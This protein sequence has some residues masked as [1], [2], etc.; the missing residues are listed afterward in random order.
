M[1]NIAFPEFVVIVV[2]ALIVIGPDKLPKVAQTLGVMVGRMQR[3]M[4][5]I[6]SD[7]DQELRNTDLHR[8]QDELKLQ[9]EGLNEELRKGMQPVADV[10]RRPEPTPTPPETTEP[11]AQAIEKEAEQQATTVKPE[12]IST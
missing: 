2:V 10:I 6:K 12:R 5:A 11:T 7:I 4:N 9:H 8:L 3:F 1:F